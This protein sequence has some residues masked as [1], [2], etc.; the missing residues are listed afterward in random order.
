M[1]KISPSG[2]FHQRRVLVAFA[3]CLIA[4][5][6]AWSQT[7]APGKSAS[8]GEYSIFELNP[9]A[10]YQW[11]QIYAGDDKSRVSKLDSGP[12]VGVR[13][14]E[15]FSK[16]VGFEQSF[17]AGFNDL[18]LLP[19]GLQQYASANER[20]YAL[21]INPVVHFTKRQ[22]R[23]RPFV[24]AGPGVVWYVPSKSLTN[25]VAGA[26]P[27][28]TELKTKYGPA[29]MFGGGIK[30]NASR[31]VGLRFDLRDTWTQGRYFELPDYP[32]GPGAIYSPKHG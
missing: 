5:V 24:T 12:V 30:F 17:T 9:F 27:L 4:V 31:R 21:V 10:G 20:N 1:F 28:T 25:T 6:P 22:S 14:T 29:L 19:F 32:F 23:V 2:L 13:F 16:Y 8:P 15:D 11:F 18:R 3:A 26:A 7:A